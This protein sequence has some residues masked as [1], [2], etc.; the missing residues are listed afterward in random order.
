MLCMMRA[1]I[2]FIV[3]DKVSRNSAMEVHGNKAIFLYL[4]TSSD[5]FSGDINLSMMDVGR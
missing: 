5:R 3:A 4:I 2:D 1:N